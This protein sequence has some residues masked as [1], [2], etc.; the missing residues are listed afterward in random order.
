LLVV[1]HESWAGTIRKYGDFA[2]WKVPVASVVE[3]DV[4]CSRKS[5]CVRAEETIEDKMVMSTADTN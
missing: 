2:V 3:D 4:S 1:R 5:N